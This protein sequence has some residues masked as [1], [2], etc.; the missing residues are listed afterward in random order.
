MKLCLLLTM[1]DGKTIQGAV[2]GGALPI[3]IGVAKTQVPQ[4]EA[5]LRPLAQA[6]P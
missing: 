3:R 4:D 5:E 1:C 2:S 6:P